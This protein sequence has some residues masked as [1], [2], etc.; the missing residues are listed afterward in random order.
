L[1]QSERALEELVPANAATGTTTATVTSRRINRL[2][3]L[4]P[5]MGFVFT[6]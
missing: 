3:I 1:A 5:K 4:T 6:A 2:M